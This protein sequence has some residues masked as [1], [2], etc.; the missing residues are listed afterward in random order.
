LEGAGAAP[1]LPPGIAQHYLPMARPCPGARLLY[2][3]M[4][5]GAAEARFRNAKFKVDVARDLV[6]LAPLASGPIPV[7]WDVAVVFEKGVTALEA[8]AEGQAVYAD[9]PPAAAN[10]RSYNVWSREFS[11]WLCHN[12]KIELFRSTA[13]GLISAPEESER[14]FRIRLQQTS[15]EARDQAVESLRRQYAPKM[16]G[17][18]ERIRRAEQAIEREAQQASTQKLSTAISVGATLLGAFLGRKAVSSGTLGRAATAARSAG[19][20][21]KEAQDVQRASE[22]LAA[23]E[24]QLAD[25]DAQFKYESAALQAKL[26]PLTE[27]LETIEIRPKKTDVAVKLVTLAWAPY[28][29]EPDGTAS[30]AW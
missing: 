25:L 26:D 16:T 3:P 23:L 8:G 2:Q 10:P 18:E 12:Q 15:R 6:F 11:T 13:A 28:S 24:Q 20:I 21:R 7:D 30:P 1:V 5:V 9:L 22:S 4:L 17:L 27:S 29:Q 19:R 14:D